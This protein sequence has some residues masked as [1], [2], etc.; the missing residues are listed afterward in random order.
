MT[1]L[2]GTDEAG[3]GP[4][5][6]PLVVSATLWHAPDLADG[7]DLHQ[8]LRDVV[9]TS[10]SDRDGT[11]RVAI[12]DSKLLYRPGSGLKQLERGVLAAWAACGKKPN[13]WRQ[14]W[15]V[16]DPDS[17]SQRKQLPWYLDYDTS[18][19]VEMSREHIEQ[20][21][22]RFQNG[23]KRAHV[24]LCSVQ[25]AAVYPQRLN[26]LMDQLGSKGT[27]LS[28]V[29]LQ[30]V[31][32]LLRHVDHGSIFIVC[33]K[34]GGRNKYR[35]LLQ[36]NFPD[37]LVEVLCEGRAESCYRT[38]P[39]ERR[40][41]FQFRARGESFLPAA[42]ASMVSKYLRELSMRAFNEFWRQFD[43]SLRPTAG[44]PVDARRFKQE[45]ARFQT[46]LAIDDCLLWRSR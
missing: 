21:A 33:D 10:P 12:A 5:L 43:P 36:E 27:A 44:Y 6:G 34:H 31:K 3:Y 39:K 29:T 22:E 28:L 15:A 45:I 41:E 24:A 20:V 18:V 42:L 1:Y 4:N 30:L 40:I 14:L 37:Y 8:R 13:T 32:K 11:G 46:K 26:R 17:D 25:S 23:L 2:L 9:S 16:A 7:E 35:K 38:G 19:P